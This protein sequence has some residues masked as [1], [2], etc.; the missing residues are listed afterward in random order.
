[1]EFTKVL[2]PK[3]NITTEL[4][5][6]DDGI[7]ELTKEKIKVAKPQSIQNGH[8]KGWQMAEW[9]NQGLFDQG[10]PEDLQGCT[11]LLPSMPQPSLSIE[12]ESGGTKNLSRYYSP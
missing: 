8:W 3:N 2:A 12:M 11:H 7:S 1:M 6:L 10:L 9:N 4:V 5:L